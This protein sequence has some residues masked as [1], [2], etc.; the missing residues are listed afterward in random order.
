MISGASIIAKLARNKINIARM[1]GYISLG[2]FALVAATWFAV[3]TALTQ[4]WAVVPIGAIV[5][6]AILMA[7]RA[8]IN[9]GVLEAEQE[10][11]FSHVPQIREIAERQNEILD[12][13]ERIEG[14]IDA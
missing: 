11:Y 5:V 3:S 6:I 9:A 7:G 8:E 10:I 4:W 14:K 13:L 12:R 2:Q 1:S